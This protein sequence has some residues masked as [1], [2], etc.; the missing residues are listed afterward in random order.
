MDVVNGTGYDNPENNKYK[1]VQARVSITPLM[2]S[3][4][5]LK[6]FTITPWFSWGG[7]TS[8][9]LNSATNPITD[10][11]QKDRYGVFVGNKDRRLTFGAEYAQRKDGADNNTTDAT[12]DQIVN[13][14]G[15][16]YD[17]FVIVRPLEFSQP[18]IKQSFGL[19][20]RFDHWKPNKDSTANAQF[21]VAGVFWE[22]TRK[23]ALA[24]D[25]Q[26]TTPKSGL[27]GA[28]ASSIFLHFNLVF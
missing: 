14:T 1:D 20:G 27:S 12:L 13:T 10:K 16:L 25:Y 15:E 9:F 8:V 26:Q 7:N 22:P 2:K 5:I 11:L 23:I 17:A 3:A 4:S 24:L 19:V 18:D 21:I 28:K 6:T